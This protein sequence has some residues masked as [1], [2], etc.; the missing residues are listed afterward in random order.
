MAELNNKAKVLST[1]IAL[2]V[3][4]ETN[5]KKDE[6]QKPLMVGEIAMSYGGAKWDSDNKT[7]V[8]TDFKFKVG[9]RDHISGRLLTWNELKEISIANLDPASIEAIAEAVEEKLKGS[10]VALNSFNSFKEKLKDQVVTGWT[11]SNDEIYTRLVKAETRPMQ[12]MDIYAEKV[13]YHHTCPKCCATCKWAKRCKTPDDYIYGISNK[14]E[15]HNPKNCTELD[16]DLD[17]RAGHCEPGRWNEPRH[18]RSKEH[19]LLD[20]HPNVTMF[21]VCDNYDVRKQQYC[22]MPGDS[23]SRIIDKRIDY[24]VDA[25]LSAFADESL[26]T[27]E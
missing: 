14:L 19:H 23:V 6:N 4:S 26:L 7:Y 11:V 13:G 25:Q 18:W 3:D 10:F 1:R 9:A 5:W 16:F 12:D 2:R 8:Y 27:L 17:H 22:P 21:G 24:A 20:L 15:C